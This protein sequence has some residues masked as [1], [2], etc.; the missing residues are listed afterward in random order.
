MKRLLQLA[1]AAT[2]ILA[3]APASA[4]LIDARFSGLVDS[5]RNTTFV[6]GAAVAGEFIYDTLTSRYVLF[7]IG[8]QSV[9]PGYL[10]SASITPDLYS[11]FYQAQLSPVVSG[12]TV[13]STFTLDLESLNRWPSGNAVALLLNATQLA[14]N[15]DTSLSTFG[16]FTGN[17]DGT[18]IRSLS[19][20]LTG[21][22]VA[23]PE[24][25]TA[26]LL[27]V[28]LAALVLPRRLRQ[29]AR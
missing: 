3:T 22:R 18:N 17:A 26:L 2:A 15:L 9:A 20:T 8:G 7:T 5:Q 28:G 6:T 14:T 16:F 27:L 11:A 23:I 25:E 21:I 4:T 13:N 1:C 12:G 19:A 10:S 24:P 29:T